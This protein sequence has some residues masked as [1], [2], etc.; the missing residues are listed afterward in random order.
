MIQKVLITGTAGF[1]GYHLVNQMIGNNCQIYGIDNLNDYYDINLK[2]ARLKEHGVDISLYEN[3]DCKN[4]S[5]Y[6][7]KLYNNYHFIHGDI[8]NKENLN[9][10][11]KSYKFDLV[12]NLAAQAGVR[13][14]LESP[15]VYIENNISGFLNILEACRYFGC[16]KVIY[17][18]T[19]SVYGLSTEMPFEECKTTDHP[20]SLYAA[21]KK[22]NELMAHTYSHLFGIETVG[23]RFFTVYGPW[24][25][26]DMAL[27]KFVKGILDGTPIDLY[28]SGDMFRDFTYVEDVT[29]VIEQ[30]VLKFDSLPYLEWDPSNPKLGV[31]SAPFRIFNIG[32]SERIN[33]K[34]Y[35]EEIEKALNKKAIINNMPFQKGDVMSTLSNT[36]LIQKYLSIRPKTPISEGIKYFVEWYKKYYSFN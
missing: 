16:N 36:D 24:G 18:S 31:S 8:F 10:L 21:T 34:V 29:K 12:V 9:N 15:E 4:Y 6:K 3:A 23:L 27:F 7:S 22:A 32:N 14:S 25:R 20:V 11:F 35:V 26:P 17:A 19:S 2:L 28:N 1:I 30:L 33:L 5:F 13:Y